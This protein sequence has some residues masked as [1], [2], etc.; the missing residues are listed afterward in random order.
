MF[1]FK[2]GYQVFRRGIG[3]GFDDRIDGGARVIS[4]I[5]IERRSSCGGVRRIIVREFG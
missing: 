5:G 3:G 1:M 4:E 2:T